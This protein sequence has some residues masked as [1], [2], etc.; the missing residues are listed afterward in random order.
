RRRRRVPAA[1]RRLRGL[2]S[3]LPAAGHARRAGGRGQPAARMVANNNDLEVPH[4]DQFSLGMRNAFEMLGQ[5]W[6]SEATL[7]YIHS[8]DGVTARLGNRREDG[9]FLPPGGTWGTPW[10]F[11]PPFGR[12]VLLDNMYETK[13]RSVLLKLDKPYTTGTGWGTTM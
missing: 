3:G 5:T 9:S 6:Y 4:S 11:D 12:I 13:T 1:Q 2:G 7:V 8:K 10:G